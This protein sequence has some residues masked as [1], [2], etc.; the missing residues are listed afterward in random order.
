MVQDEYSSYVVTPDPDDTDPSLYVTLYFY[1]HDNITNKDLT[2]SSEKICR[3][4]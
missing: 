4:I 1:V 2:P 3:E